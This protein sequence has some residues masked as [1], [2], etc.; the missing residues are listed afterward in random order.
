MSSQFESRRYEIESKIKVRKRLSILI[1]FI[2]SIGFFHFDILK[3]FNLMLPSNIQGMISFISLFFLG[4]GYAIFKKPLSHQKLAFYEIVEALKL[5][6]KPGKSETLNLKAR[7]RV[8]KAYKWLSNSKIGD[9]PWYSELIKKEK[10]F[11]NNLKTRVAPAIINDTIS[12]T[13][14]LDIAMALQGNHISLLENINNALEN[15]LEEKIEDRKIIS[16]FVSLIS[17]SKYMMAVVFFIA[18]LI[19]VSTFL[20]VITIYIVDLN[21]IE[22]VKEE[23]VEVAA[24]CVLTFVSL[25][26]V[27]KEKEKNHMTYA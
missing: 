22:V 19:T 20:Y 24:L 10:L 14:L 25:F 12:P 8:L 21:F 18:A 27:L 4:Y 15:K 17:S 6:E 2:G 3:Y 5:I 9:A 11:I 16:N 13:Y 23:P 26:Q 1:L 7:K